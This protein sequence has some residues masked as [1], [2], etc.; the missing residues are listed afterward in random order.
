MF[1]EWRYSS[2]ERVTTK[3]LCKHSVF[4]CVNRHNTPGDS[5]ASLRAYSLLH[6]DVTKRQHFSSQSLWQFCCS[7]GLWLKRTCQHFFLHSV[8][9]NIICKRLSNGGGETIVFCFFK[10]AFIIHKYKRDPCKNRQFQFLNPELGTVFLSDVV[11][12]GFQP[13]Q[14]ES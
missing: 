13:R 1:I 4:C 9:G 3:E 8:S 5:T 11:V 7:S 10:I 6:F 14:I 12:C 2:C